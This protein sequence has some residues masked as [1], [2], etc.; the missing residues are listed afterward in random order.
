M[1]HE[2][3]LSAPVWSRMVLKVEEESVNRS[4]SFFLAES[5]HPSPCWSQDVL[6]VIFLIFFLFVCWVSNL[7]HI[8][9]TAGWVMKTDLLNHLVTI[10]P[11]Q[12]CVHTVLC[13]NHV[14]SYSWAQ[15]LSFSTHEM[16]MCVL[17]EPLCS[18][19]LLVV[20]RYNRRQINC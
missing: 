9:P 14:Y 18:N 7:I 10:F 19:K 17:L 4:L 13:L 15:N 20:S 16:K 6:A 5:S 12:L 8:T 1:S 2:R 11:H 3:S